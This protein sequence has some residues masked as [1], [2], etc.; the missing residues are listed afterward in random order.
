MALPENLISRRRSQYRD[1]GIGGIEEGL[2]YGSRFN[3]AGVK[4]SKAEVVDAIVI[5]VENCAVI[6]ANVS[7]RIDDFS[8]RGLGEGQYPYSG[9]TRRGRIIGQLVF[10]KRAKCMGA[11]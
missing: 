8:S 3:M 2:P 5:E 1:R 6:D 11:A 10:Q 9:G 4:T 7:W